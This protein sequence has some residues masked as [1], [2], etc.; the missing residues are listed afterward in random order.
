M[1]NY[2]FVTSKG[3]KIFAECVPLLSVVNNSVFKFDGGN[4]MRNC[5]I[6][7]LLKTGNFKIS[8]KLVSF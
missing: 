4:V 5:D 6:D 3:Y 8:G 7:N 1:L 2:A